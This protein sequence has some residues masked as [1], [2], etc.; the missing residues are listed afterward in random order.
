M[1]SPSL[2]RAQNTVVI[3]R[4]VGAAGAARLPDQIEQRLL[5]NCFGVQE[6]VQSLTNQARF[7]LSS[8]CRQS[9]EPAILLRRQQD[10]HARHAR[11]CSHNKMIHMIDVARKAVQVAHDSATRAGI[12]PPPQYSGIPI[13]LG[14][15]GTA[16]AAAALR[17][18]G[19][20]ACQTGVGGQPDYLPRRFFLSRPRSS[21]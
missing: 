8:L 7:R 13:A 10:L 21:T 14:A 16:T 12:A 15:N 9:L 19:L 1:V 6:K 17:Q 11:V 4:Y 3:T 18:I 2:H 5:L 20:T